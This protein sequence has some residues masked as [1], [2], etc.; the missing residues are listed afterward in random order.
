MHAAESP[1]YTITTVTHKLRRNENMP[2]HVGGKELTIQR[3]TKQT[4]A[5][6]FTY[7]QHFLRTNVQMLRYHA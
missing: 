1:W 3:V 4:S 5:I 7:T 2:I 6:M